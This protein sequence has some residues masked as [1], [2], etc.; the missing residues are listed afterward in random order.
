[1]RDGVRAAATRP[2]GELGKA[3]RGGPRLCGLLGRLALSCVAC[4]IWTAC[5]T[6]PERAIPSE[7]HAPA[8]DCLPSDELEPVVAM[9]WRRA[10]ETFLEAGQA[11][12]T[13]L[14]D[15]DVWPRAHADEL[16]VDFAFD[17]TISIDPWVVT[18]EC[19]T[20]LDLAELRASAVAAERVL[21]DVVHLRVVTGDSDSARQGD[22]FFTTGTGVIEVRV[23]DLVRDSATPW[24][25]FFEPLWGEPRIALRV[26]EPSE[27]SSP[28]LRLEGLP[29][30][31][32][33]AGVVGLLEVGDAL[34]RDEE[35]H[36]A[37]L[38]GHF[39]EDWPAYTRRF[40]A[41]L[42]TEFPAAPVD[43]PEGAALGT[44]NAD[45]AEAP[46]L[47][48]GE[49]L[50][51]LLARDEEPG[52]VMVPCGGR[53]HAF[54]PSLSTTTFALPRP[55][56]TAPQPPPRTLGPGMALDLVMACEGERGRLDISARSENGRDT[57]L[58]LTLVA[59]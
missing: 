27:L 36:T 55:T 11:S 9:P 19:P 57:R 54:S 45:L 44:Q 15:Y 22:L 1:M 13:A 2:R 8:A 38:P 7:Y 21:G 24:L 32:G 48:P 10:R 18:G 30:G 20:R 3:L 53:V 17:E 56:A 5:S 35:T 47:M 6:D 42:V 34:T 59:P 23:P 41:A 14:L 16:W 37:Y 28:T 4:L 39:A 29:E 33:F 31:A 26:V 43:L 58:W 49:P 25:L 50:G 40:A 12:D 51:L 46:E 52:W